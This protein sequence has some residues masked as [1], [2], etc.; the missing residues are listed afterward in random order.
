MGCEGDRVAL[1]VGLNPEHA[2]EDRADYHSRRPDLMWRIGRE[3][4]VVISGEDFGDVAQ[5][6]IE[7]Q[8]CVG[9]QIRISWKRLVVAVFPDRRPSRKER[10]YGTE[11]ISSAV[12]KRGAVGDDAHAPIGLLIGLRKLPNG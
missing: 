11:M 3:R 6:S 5:G 12:I 2:A 1:Y 10:P 9:A 7:H 8:Q 4:L